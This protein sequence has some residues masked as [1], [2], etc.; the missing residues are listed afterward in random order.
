MNI[1]V[2]IQ[3]V[4][5]NTFPI[6]AGCILTGHWP[7]ALLMLMMLTVWS[8][9]SLALGVLRA[10]WFKKSVCVDVYLRLCSSSSSPR[11]TEDRPFRDRSRLWRPLIPCRN[12]ETNLYSPIYDYT[13]RQCTVHSPHISSIGSLHCCQGA[14]LA[15]GWANL[16]WFRV[17]SE[18]LTQAHPAGCFA[19]H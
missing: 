2:I 13:V 1:N 15:S 17:S 12:I 7:T 14:Q 6:V 11:G 10:H 9:T 8:Y 18:V 4:I 19:S 5:L 3:D 16:V